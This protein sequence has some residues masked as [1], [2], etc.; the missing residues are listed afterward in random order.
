M[1]FSYRI[2]TTSL[3]VRD[4][5]KCTRKEPR[6]K[7]TIMNVQDILEADPYNRS[8]YHNIRKL[9]GLKKGEGIFRLRIGDYRIRYDIIG[10][11]IVL[12]SFRNRK[13]AYR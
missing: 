9:E 12:Y 8:G 11:G 5:K 4:V 6:L 10:N 7:A 2:V 13:D 3:F 1:Q